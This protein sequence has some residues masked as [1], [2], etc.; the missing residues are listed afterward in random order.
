LAIER[1]T[2]FTEHR[3]PAERADALRGR[4]PAAVGAVVEPRPRS[5]WGPAWSWAFGLVLGI[6]VVGPGWSTDALLNLDLVI[7]DRMPVPDWWGIGPAVPRNGPL[8]AAIALLS[9]VLPGPLLV[10]ATMALS[11]AAAFAGMARLA[12]GSGVAGQVMAGVLYAAG[13]FML[14]RIGV[15]HLGLV[16]AA[17]LLPW[18]L[19]TLLRPGDE[20]RRTFLWSLAFSATGY[21]GASIAA[22]ALGTGLVADRLRRGGAVV[23]CFVFAQLPW[24]LPGAFVLAAGPRVADAT[25]FATD[26][27]GP[28]GVLGI[29]L[30]YGF[31]QPANQIGVSGPWVSVL[32]LGVLALAVLGGRELP[33]RWRDRSL[34]LAVVGT[35]IAL[36]SAVPVLDDLYGA[37]S[38]TPLGQPLR[39][40]QRA[41][42]LALVWLAPAAAHGARRIGMRFDYAALRGAPAAVLAGCLLLAVSPWLWG[43]GGRLEPVDVPASWN[44]ARELVAGD[45]TVLALPWHQYFDLEVAE[46]RRV[47]HPLPVFLP[48]DVIAS[49]DPELGPN[50]RET[51]DRR[52]DTIRGLLA[53]LDGGA[54]ITADIERL[55]VRW[56][57]ALPDLGEGRLRALEKQ[58]GLTRLLEA[59]EVQVWEVDGWR[60]E[61]VADGGQPVTLDRLAPPFATIDSSGAAT[62]H[63]AGGPGWLRGLQPASVTTEGLLRV[64]AGS[65]P[66]WFWPAVLVLC[67]DLAVAAAA[68]LAVLSLA[69]DPAD[70]SARRN[71]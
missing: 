65:G 11:I 48:G 40:S 67:A 59:A 35:G 1:G 47:H 31:W 28:G 46:G 3:P 19:P 4:V 60:G 9:Q 64:P 12:D 33:G 42:L 6:A 69:R 36:A 44:Q 43:L 63:R 15:G 25:E 7:F 52:E 62:W 66:L 8:T 61:A 41:L 38:E 68:V 55:G 2:T 13:P 17:A 27:D 5:S 57:V 18:A 22:I 50:L 29:F 49:S 45:G 70:R 37:I 30:G 39:E 14:T 51:A 10:T 34:A 53:E 56:I 58:P 32:A 24:A 16:L 71:S 54:S 26:L 21:Y 23:G 20:L